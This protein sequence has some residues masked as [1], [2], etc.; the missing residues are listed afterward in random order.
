MK[1]LNIRYH[2]AADTHPER[3]HCR[4]QD[5]VDKT[6]SSPRFQVYHMACEQTVEEDRDTGNEKLIPLICVEDSKAP[7]E[8]KIPAVLDTAHYENL[9]I[10]VEVRYKC[11]NYIDD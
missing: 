5:R 11:R 1:L 6:F 3:L 10:V 8:I 2:H 7:I 9:V 4:N